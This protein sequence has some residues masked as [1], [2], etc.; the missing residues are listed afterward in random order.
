MIS[1]LTKNVIDNKFVHCL[2]SEW[3]TFMAN[4]PPD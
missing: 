1:M 3:A 4:D 2:K